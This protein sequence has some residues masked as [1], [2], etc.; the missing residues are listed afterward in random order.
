MAIT[1]W[2]IAALCIALGLFGTLLP[3]LP[4]GPLV[5]LGVLLGAW[6]DHFARVGLWTL[7]GCAALMVIGL[8]VDLLA[9]FFGAKRSGAS[10]AAL[11]GTVLGSLVGVFFV[12]LGILL[13]PLVGALLGQY[14][15]DRDLLRAGKVGLGTWLGLV[16]GTV[17][18]LAL[19][20]AMILLFLVVYLW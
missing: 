19:N 6:A 16:V 9:T 1:L 7:L 4:G 17:V 3:I 18:K 10:K 5:F 14:Y 11:T 12:P 20:C 13:G 8:V 2:I 15:T